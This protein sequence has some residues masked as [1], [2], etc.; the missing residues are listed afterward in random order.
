MAIWILI[1]E[2]FAVNG[3]VLGAHSL[4]HRFGLAHFYAL[5]GGLTAVMS[6]ITDAGVT[7]QAVGVTFLVG[8]TVFY[9]SILLGVFVIY[10]FDGPRATRIAI[11]TVV[12]V[13][14]MVPVIALVLHLQMKLMGS[15]PLGY[16]PLPSLRINTASVLA[17][18]AD[19]V[20]LAVAW[21]F[22]HARLGSGRTALSSF[23]TL[24]GVMWLDVFLF[25]VGAF[26][27]SP[28]F[29]ATISG[30]L[31]SRA[32]V[33]IFAAPLLWLYLVWQERLKGIKPESRPLLAILHMFQ[34]MEQELDL[35]KAEIDL[36]AE[37]EEKLR[38][39][40]GRLAAAIEASGAGVFEHNLPLD[41]HGIYVSPRWLELHEM[42]PG[43]A[44]PTKGARE[45]LDGFT[46]PDDIALFREAH[47]KLVSG[48][49]FTYEIE[50]R[51]KDHNGEWKD[52][53]V[54]GRVVKPERRGQN[55]KV[56]GVALDINQRKKAE[57]ADLERAKMEGV[58]EMA[59][60][61]CHELNQPLQ[62]LFGQAELLAG[63]KAV[64]PETA[65]RAEAIMEELSRIVDIIKKIQ[66][67][68]KYETM[69]Y[70]GSS[71]IV[72]IGKSSRLD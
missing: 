38:L 44:P 54:L 22:F 37:A 48:K 35:A 3:L 33:T 5:L 70:V 29:G 71:K 36:R 66:S 59:G 43:T 17:T 2:A 52:L 28:G 60:A 12:G 64:R 49:I 40:E 62:V 56:V 19:L 1:L 13:S 11:S 53:L 30:T 21:E 39:S 42:E 9:T 50:Y 15:A 32:V 34:E 24:L 67:I 18:L 72:D 69:D 63:D 7:V 23:I 14:I 26:A 46:H 57:E 31:I 61:A 20:F 65:R 10:V 25:N 8:S 27:G 45:W 16:V 6:W 4:R 55:A 68:T 47:Q 51:I 58:M 41:D